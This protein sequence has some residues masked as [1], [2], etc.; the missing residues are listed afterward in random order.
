MDFIKTMAEKNT[1]VKVVYF[2]KKDH[3][4]RMVRGRI[5]YDDDFFHIENDHQN[6][7]ILPTTMMLKP[8][9]EKEI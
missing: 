7:R 4:N 1:L 6:Q 9:G 5:S 8:H 3:S 2:S